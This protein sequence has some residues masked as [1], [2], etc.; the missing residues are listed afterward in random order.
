LEKY[1]IAVLKGDGIGPEIIDQA[2][3][4]LCAVGNKYGIH[5]NFTEALIG[6]AAIDI[7]GSPLPEDTVDICK[8]SDAVL[9]GSVGGPK[10]ENLNGNNTPESGLLAIREKLNL[11]AN[12]RYIELLK[13]LKSISPLKGV[14]LKNIDIVIVRELLG[15]MYFGKKGK[16]CSDKDIVAYDTETYSE[17]E[18]ARIAKVAF[19]IAQKRNKKVLSVDKA[20]VL[21]TS[22]LWRATVAN[23]AKSYPDVELNHMYVDN[24]A[25]Q[26]I[27]NPWDFDVI[28]TSNM[29]GDI[30]SDE[31]SMLCGSLGLLPSASLSGNGFG[32]YEPAHGSAPD[33][34]GKDL[35]NPLA[36]ILSASLML[37][38][39]LN[40]P[41]AANDIKGAVVKVLS[42]YRTFDL[43]ET[44]TTK[45]S[46]SEMGKL[47]V[48]EIN[49]VF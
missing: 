35:A 44:N 11:Y 48:D 18:I 3:N 15:G 38:L 23:I 40:S 25:M 4:V 49:N 39:S 26:I 10:W 24:C 14:N 17:L 2:I 21:T 43:V 46:C 8:S 31:A 6:G 47:L 16:I 33:I 41:I 32:L 1:N 20:N 7:Q 36:A 12:L 34:A 5:F 37:E 42:K 22:R 19:E 29:F 45:V 13:P 9:L 28:L 30:L 27:R